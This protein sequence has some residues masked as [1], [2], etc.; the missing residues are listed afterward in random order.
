M[1]HIYEFL[2]DPEDQ[3]FGM[4]AISLVDR[5]AIESE[6]IAFNKQEKPVIFKFRD[7]KK[8]I[9]SGLAL[10]PN[11]LI[12]RVDE[13][14]GE[15]YMGFF[16]EDTIEQIMNKFMLEST[17]GTTKNVNF[18][19]NPDNQVQAHLIESFILRTPEMVEAVKL[20]GIEEAVLG[21]WFVSYK[22]DDKEAYETAIN[23][24]F[25]GFSIEVILQKE[26]RLNKNNNKNN[27][28]LMAKV[29]K[30]IEKFKTIL[31]EYE[32]ALTFE[33]VNIADGSG[34]L[35]IGEI[36]TPVLKVIPAE[37]GTETTEPVVAGEYIIEDGRTIVVDD[38]GNL[39]EIRE[40]DA[41][42]EPAMPDA[43]VPLAEV[44][45]EVPVEN[46][47]EE[48]PAIV[49]EVP[50]ETPMVDVSAKTLGEIVDVSKDGEYEI[51]VLVAGGQI[52]EAT[53]EAAQNLIGEFNA[54]KSEIETLKAEVETLKAQLSKPVAR[55]VFE[56][57]TPRVETKTKEDLKKM[58]NLDLVKHR[59]GLQ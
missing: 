2:I 48:V 53:V 3:E 43:E 46:K 7:D 47:L 41:P 24:N 15:E 23:G 45:V 33:D 16:S 34:I 11:K 39:L 14:T 13:F 38:M 1:I 57:S 58:S 30:L 4:K 51:K 54:Q 25:T 31:N 18:Q 22:F 56:I 10:I 20:M 59:L 50:A 29:N 5:P 12:Y 52:T 32:N 49:P 44:P 9:V 36:G 37:D 8:Y 21:A 27:N 17:N 26:L 42:I 35:R 19:H 28:I 55:P 6:Y 40:A